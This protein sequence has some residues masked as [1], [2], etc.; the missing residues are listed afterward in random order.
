LDDLMP[1]YTTETARKHNKASRRSAKAQRA[2]AHAATSVGAETGD[3]G[4]AI[5]AGNAAADRSLAKT[6]RGKGK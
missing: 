3:E 2:F 4:R 5:R 1:P 6:R